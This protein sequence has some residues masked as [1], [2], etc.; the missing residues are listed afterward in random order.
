MLLSYG[1][2]VDRLIDPIITYGTA[3][4]PRRGHIQCYYHMARLIDPI[5]TYGTATGPRRGYIQC[6]YHMAPPW[7][8]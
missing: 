3:T 8:G 7:T 5:I 4:G 1:P 6:Y 2:A